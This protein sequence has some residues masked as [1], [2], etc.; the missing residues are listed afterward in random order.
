M[1]SALRKRPF[2]PACVAASSVS[3]PRR[4]DTGSTMVSQAGRRSRVVAGS[5]R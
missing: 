4:P 2:P 3:V 1:R 5:G